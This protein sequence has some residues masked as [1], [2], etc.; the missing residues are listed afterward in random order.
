MFG[1]LFARNSTL[2]IQGKQ[3]PTTA[4][5]ESSMTVVD[6]KQRNILNIFDGLNINTATGSD[7]IP[8]KVQQNI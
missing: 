5:V 2:G 4:E 6:F 1:D 7:L 3:P 8:P